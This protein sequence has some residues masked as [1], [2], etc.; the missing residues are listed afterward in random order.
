M[1]KTDK[2]WHSP[3]KTFWD[4]QDFWGEVQK[5]VAK[6]KVEY[7]LVGEA[8][9]AMVT[10]LALFKMTGNQTYLQLHRPDPPDAYL[11]WA[12]KGHAIITSLEITT[13]DGRSGEEFIEQIKRSKIPGGVPKLSEK[14]V[15]IYELKTDTPIDF[16][17]AKQELNKN[18]LV[19]FPVWTVRD[20]G[21]LVDTTAE[22]TVV[23]PTVRRLEINIGEAAHEL[24]KLG[25]L[26][27]VV[28]HRAGSPEKVRAE[29][30]EPILDPP[31]DTI[32]KL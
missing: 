18:P 4:I 17:H 6:S 30:A 9:I 10:A 8:K 20:T 21:N 24:K 15:L 27:T 11:M 22:L 1:F 26:S 12:S 25:Q 31:W 32:G 13:F 23:N 5:G 2:I 7:Q 19:K 16:N 14:D 28:R 3:L 29:P